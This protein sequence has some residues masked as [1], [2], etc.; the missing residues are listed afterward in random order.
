[1]PVGDFGCGDTIYFSDV[2]LGTHL[3][4]EYI[5]SS[6]HRAKLL[7]LGAS[8]FNTLFNQTNIIES[9]WKK[10]KP[11]FVIQM[12]QKITFKET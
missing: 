11:I 10:T 3:E 4:Y 6:S 12:H 7:K 8:L 2:G 9:I 1:M 5:F